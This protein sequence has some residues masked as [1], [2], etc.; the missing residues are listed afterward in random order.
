MVGAVE[1]LEERLRAAEARLVEELEVA[2]QRERW[3]EQEFRYLRSA[4]WV[5][6]RL[7]CRRARVGPFTLELVERPD[8]DCLAEGVAPEA[9]PRALELAIVDG[10]RDPERLSE[11]R[12]L[13][14][15]IG[16]VIRR[17]EELQRLLA[18]GFADGTALA[19]VREAKDAIEEAKTKICLEG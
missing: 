10:P 16:G 3:W 7:G 13:L 1:R 11:A 9:C 15:R 5:L 2:S 18:S 8:P 12:R 17:M 19:A 14:D 4:A 6:E